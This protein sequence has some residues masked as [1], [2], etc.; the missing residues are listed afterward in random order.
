MQTKDN[1]DLWWD[2]VCEIRDI[3]NQTK[4]RSAFIPWLY[5][6]YPLYA[7]DFSNDLDALNAAFEAGSN[8]E[9]SL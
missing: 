4:Y 7:F 6:N 8:Y 1:I 3:K 2:R 5:K 9:K